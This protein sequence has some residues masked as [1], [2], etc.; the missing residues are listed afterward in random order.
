MTRARALPH[1]TR[2]ATRCRLPAATALAQPLHDLCSH[3]TCAVLSPPAVCEHGAP[4]SPYLN[5]FPD[6]AEYQKNFPRSN[7]SWTPQNFSNYPYGPQD[8]KF[9]YHN[10]ARET[11]IQMFNS[12]QLPVKAAIAKEFAVFNALHSSVPSYSTPNHLFWGFGSS[13]GL[14]T[15]PRCNASGYEPPAH[16]FDSLHAA[17]VSYRSYSNDSAASP[18]T[19]GNS[20]GGS[21]CP[22]DL[23]FNA[24]RRHKDHCVSMDQFYKDAAAVCN[25]IACCAVV[26]CFTAMPL[27][28]PD[29]AICYL[30]HREVKF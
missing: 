30:P 15:N 5:K 7:R 19:G 29:D 9:S 10:G 13:C 2:P 25:T 1:R 8:D 27:V 20:S 3:A 23:M 18:P 14:S 28:H 26:L 6:L 24:S 22:F 11:A 12:T 16:I 17:N 4:Y 21:A